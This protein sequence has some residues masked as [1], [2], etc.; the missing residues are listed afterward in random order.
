MAGW[1]RDLRIDCIFVKIAQLHAVKINA[2]KTIPGRLPDYPP[3]VYV[4]N[5][6]E[7]PYRILVFRLQG[8][9]VGSALLDDRTF[10]HDE[11]AVADVVS[12]ADVVGDENN[13]HGELFFELH[14]VIQDI[15][16]NACVNHAGG[17][18]GDEHLGPQNENAREEHALHLPSRKFE[19]ILALDFGG[20][21]VNGQKRLINAFVHFP[22]GILFLENAEGAFKLGAYGEELV[23]ATERILEH[24][25]HL[26]PVRA[27][28][29]DEGALEQKFARRGPDEAEHDL[30]E[31]AFAAARTA[32]QGNDFLVRDGKAYV[33]HGL[34]HFFAVTE[35][36]RYVVGEKDRVFSLHRRTVPVFR[37]R[38]EFPV[39]LPCN[40]AAP[41]GT[42]RRTGTPKWVRR[43]WAERL[44]WP[45]VFFAFARVRR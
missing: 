14:Q 37:R 23:E 10:V 9:V 11:K 26:A 16:A 45:R 21:D 33:V 20:F 6:I 31:H 35:P 28:V 18:V 41:R 29:A 1:L 5:V 44:R 4:G 34:D 7:Q 19:G 22:F 43:G 17:L 8:D 38:S 25:L 13:G 3:L 39:A 42:A 32:H 2:M 30:G 36:A 24:R 40:R 15:G 27:L 12:Q